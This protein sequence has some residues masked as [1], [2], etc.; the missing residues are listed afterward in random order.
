MRR[1]ATFF[2]FA[3]L[4]CGA[5]PAAPRS[6]PPTPVFVTLDALPCFGSCASYHAELHLDGTL[7]LWRQHEPGATEAA[8]E[9]FTRVLDAAALARVRQT[10]AE[11]AFFALDA[12]GALPRPLPPGV[13]SGSTTTYDFT[14][15]LVCGDSPRTRVLY[16][17]EGRERVIEADHCNATPFIEL[18]TKLVELFGI[19]A[20]L[21]E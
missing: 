17:D 13:T 6:P 1:R 14:D 18:E 10:F 4:G 2:A 21:R 3:L 7:V 12:S 8:P 5:A 19:D 20:W 16:R 11:A 9:P 15:L